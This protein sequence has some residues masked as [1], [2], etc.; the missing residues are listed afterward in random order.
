MIRLS[1]PRPAEDYLGRLSRLRWRRALAPV[2][3]AV[4]GVLEVRDERS[5]PAPGAANALAA[6]A[7]MPSGSIY[8]LDS[9]GSGELR[10]EPPAVSTLREL[11]AVPAASPGIA[12]LAG[13]PERYP[14][15]FLVGGSPGPP[16]VA[17]GF[18]VVRLPETFGAR[19]EILA[20]IPA[21]ARRL[22]DVGCGAGETAAAAR[23]RHPGLRVEG[24][25]RDPRLAALA[26][27]ALDVVHEGDALEMLRALGARRERF[28]VLVFADSIEHFRDPFE[29]LEAAR[30]IAAPGATLVVSVPNA[31]AA[32]IVS[33]LLRG[34]FD[35]VGAGP[36]D[37][38]HLRWLTRRSLEE[39]LEE[40]GFEDFRADPLP[41][42]GENGLAEELARA[43]VRADAAS[44]GAIQWIATARYR[45]GP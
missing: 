9:E 15:R 39:L 17:R 30:E 45:G 36:E 22:I 10:W 44:L 6:C 40:T 23:R 43:G 8:P 4:E 27:A 34:R 35:P 16:F 31:G 3:N 25:E 33:D 28:D 7:E 12:P 21:G 13:A 2:E 1:F 11:E 5:L 19:E 41:H 29:T 24:I 18:R 14:A 32:A 37:A 26:R 20:R 42:P 38:G